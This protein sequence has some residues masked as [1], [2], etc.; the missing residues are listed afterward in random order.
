MLKKVVFFALAIVLVF[1]GLASAAQNVANTNQKGSLLV[2]PK[3]VALSPEQDTYI[4]IGNDWYQDIWVKCYWMDSNQTVE[5]FVFRLTPNQPVGFSAFFGTDFGSAGLITVPPFQGIG[6]LQCWVVNDASATNQIANNHLYGNAWIRDDR[7]FNS[8][9]VYNAWAFTARATQFAVVGTTPGLLELDGKAGHYDACPAYLVTNFSPGDIDFDDFQLTED[10]FPDLTL[11]PCKQDLTQDRKPTCTKAKFDIWNANET[12]FT[13][14]YKCI[15][16]WF[17]GILDGIT[18]PVTDNH[19][20]FSPIAPSVTDKFVGYGGEKFSIF[21]LKTAAA[22]FRVTGQ[23][24]TVCKSSLCTDGQTVSPFLGLM[25][26]LEGEY[27][28]PFTKPV[29]GYTLATAGFADGSTAALSAGFIKW[30][31]SGSTPEKPVR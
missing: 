7:V 14:A 12:K 9:V 10:T 5:D 18:Y 23:S 19:D 21:S 15:K 8:N 30:D 25:L 4:Y 20:N 13:G 27:R 11:W 26:Y 24:S 3:I 6:S 28:G 29:A 31:A 2:W 17:E 1:V 22:R 16:C